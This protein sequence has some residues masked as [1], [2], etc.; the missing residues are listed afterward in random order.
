MIRSLHR[1]SI[2]AFHL[3]IKSNFGSKNTSE[4]IKAEGIQYLLRSRINFVCHIPII[5][6]VIICGIQCHNNS[7]WP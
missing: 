1:N 2:G 3:P 5:T 6:T 4:R 7:S